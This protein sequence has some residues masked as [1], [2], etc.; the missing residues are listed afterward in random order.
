MRTAAHA[1]TASSPCRC[2]PRVAQRPADG[3][4]VR[5]CVW[6][7]VGWLR[8][9]VSAQ[10]SQVLA[11]PSNVGYETLTNHLVTRVNGE[12]VTSLLQMLRIVDA[13]SQPYV[14]FD[15]EPHDECVVLDAKTL[16]AVNAELLQQHQIP[17]DRSADLRRAAG[18]AGSSS[19][20]EA[21]GA[22][23]DAKKQRKRAR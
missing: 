8:A 6:W 13:N 3:T 22:A 5:V 4:C 11:H 10:L 14:Q 21:N 23:P 1:P 19:G 9:C 20:H 7:G 18:G 15:L 2:P 16:T 17:A 12:K